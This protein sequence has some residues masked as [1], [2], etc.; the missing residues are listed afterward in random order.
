MGG[1]P[2]RGSEGPGAVDV[3]GVADA[4]AD[5]DTERA[6]APAIVASAR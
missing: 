5:A 2:D 4:D 3:D 1:R 6:C